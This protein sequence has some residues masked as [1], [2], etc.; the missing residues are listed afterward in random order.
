MAINISDST[1]CFQNLF[2]RYINHRLSVARNSLDVI[3]VYIFS[4][5]HYI[6]Y[7]NIRYVPVWISN[8]VFQIDWCCV[9]VCM[10]VCVYVEGGGGVGVGGRRGW[11]WKF[12]WMIFFTPNILTYIFGGNIFLILVHFFT[13][14]AY[15][16]VN[17]AMVSSQILSK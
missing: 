10:C 7:I 12:W 8:M 14:N 3:Q 11:S 15:L 16:L 4:S 1:T 13:V 17:D 9:C 2:G 6:C 5:L